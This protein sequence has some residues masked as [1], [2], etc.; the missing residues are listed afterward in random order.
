MPSPSM[1]AK[2]LRV[3]EMAAL[4]LMAA[5]MFGAK[6]ALAWLPN[7]HLGALLLT[8]TTLLFGWRALYTAL[9]YTLLEGLVYG[10]GLWWVSYLYAWP[11]L[12]A[13]IMPLRR[14]RSWLLLSLAAAVHGYLFGALC[15]IPVAAISGLRAAAAWWAAG[16]PYDL[17]HGTGNLV[18]CLC[19]LRPLDSVLRRAWGSVGGE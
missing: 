19:L 2:G 4:A 6:L 5:L 15:A 14:G 8:L 9:L 1:R 12:V 16:I 10:F 11:L 3:R 7:L 17:I 18:L 13:M